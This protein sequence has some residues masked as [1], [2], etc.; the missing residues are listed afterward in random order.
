MKKYLVY[1]STLIFFPVCLYGQAVDYA[2]PDQV[3][4]QGDGAH[5]GNASPGNVCYT[6]DA[7]E[8][9]D[10]NDIHNSFPTV[11][12]DHTTTYTVHV[13]GNNFSFTATDQVKVI[14]HFGGLVI[15]PA[16][17]KLSDNTTNQATATLTVNDGND[18]ITWAIT[19]AGST[20]CLID[21]NGVISGCTG[22]GSVN[23]VATSQTHPDCFAKK[24]LEIN[25]GV[26]D[27]T[28]SDNANE[29][30]IAH[31]GEK[32][33]LVGPN[34]GGPAGTAKFTAVPNENSN[35][36][37]GQPAWS[38]PYMPPAGQEV[39]WDSPQLPIGTYAESAGTPDPKTV[40][41]QVVGPN[42]I[43]IQLSVNT[44]LVNQLIAKIKGEAKPS[45]STFCDSP[46]AIT[47][48]TITATGK[49]YN[50]PKFKDLNY[51][52][53]KEVAIDIPGFT[54]TGCMYFPCCTGGVR[55]SQNIFVFYYTYFGSSLKFNI[56]LAGSIDPSTSA[57]PQWE[58]A[59][60]TI[61]V[62][63]KLEA[64]VRVEGDLGG[65]AGVIAGASLSTEGKLEARKATGQP[66]LEW[67]A[68]WGGLVGKITA[69]V[70]YQTLD[71]AIGV[72][73]QRNLVNGSETGWMTLYDMSGL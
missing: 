72:E 13:V 25:G 36:P 5:I 67:N 9:L 30:R 53:K 4:C 40:T 3:A 61:S 50:V 45:N 7:T 22:T 1:I 15:N 21:Q 14:V 10:P 54:M 66:K 33:Y 70:W 58:L 57:N 68:S 60:P 52:T 47:L 37:A 11:H 41:V 16:Y 26:K 31:K 44:V 18:P 19:G 24:I 71:N 39:S 38:G 2:G 20:G 59:N 62:T 32:L 46:F 69:A 51:A 43:N 17:I 29:G 63:G 64:G 23:V 35:F 73:F 48:P 56:N 28:A 8:G 34:T 55:F 6:W 65:F 42:E 27:V 49:L 12:P